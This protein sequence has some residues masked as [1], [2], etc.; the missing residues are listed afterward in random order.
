MTLSGK[1]VEVYAIFG[2]QW[3]HSS[4][5]IP[6]G[7]MCGPTLSDVTRSIAILDYWKREWLEKEWLGCSIDRW[8][9]NKTWEDVWAWAEE[10]DAQRNS[11]CGL[12]LRFAKRAG[13]DTFGFGC[14][15]FLAT[16][17]YFQPELY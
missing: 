4:F 11:D 12:F 5:M 15:K 10:N 14:G 6:G 3:P 13:L 16:G 1:P 17:T 9:E 2:G 7:V 8:M